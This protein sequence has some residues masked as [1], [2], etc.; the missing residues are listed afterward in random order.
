[1]TYIQN[2]TKNKAIIHQSLIILIAYLGKFVIEIDF[3][4]MVKT[5]FFELGNL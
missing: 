4:L 5:I 3:W 1:M 2:A